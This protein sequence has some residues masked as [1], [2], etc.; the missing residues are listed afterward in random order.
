MKQWNCVL[1]HADLARSS[2]MS[3]MSLSLVSFSKIIPKNKCK[4]KHGNVNM[5]DLVLTT[6]HLW[7]ISFDNVKDMC[8]VTVSSPCISNWG[9]VMGAGGYSPP[10]TF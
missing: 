5:K 7:D 2:I 1:A 4:R 3:A 10:P 8:Q 6:L 9:G